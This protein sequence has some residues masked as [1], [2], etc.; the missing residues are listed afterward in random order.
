M[1]LNNS[2]E[3]NISD[4]IKTLPGFRKCRN[5]DL[6]KIIPFISFKEIESDEYLYKAG[7]KSENL[8]FLIEGKIGLFSGKEIFDEISYGYLGEESIDE[9]SYKVDVKALSKSKII[10][11]PVNSLSMIMDV[12]PEFK[13]EIYSSMINHYIKDKK[14]R[15]ISRTNEIEKPLRN[16]HKIIGWLFTIIVPAVIYW[17]V[18]SSDIFE[19]NCK[20]FLTIFSAAITMWIF[21]LLDE[22]I[23]CVFVIAS[24]LI[25][26]VAPPEK[27]LSGFM[28]DEFFLVLSIFGIASVLISSG[29]TYRFVLFVLKYTPQSQ[30][31][32]SIAL[33]F[34]GG[35]ITPIIPSANARIILV[36]PI[37]KDMNE[38]LGYKEAGKASTGLSSA[39][40]HGFTLFSSV[41]LSSKT[42][43]FVVLGLLPEQIKDQFYWISWF[44][45]ALATGIIL[46][47][48]YVCFALLFFRSSE[49]PRSSRKQ[50]E[51]QLKVLGPVTA[52]EKFALLGVLIFIIGIF[53]SSIHKIQ[54]PWLSIAILYFLLSFNI[55]SKKDFRSG[56]DW[57]FLF[58]LGGLIGIVKV[59][60]FVGFDN[61]I[62]TKLSWLGIYMR[63]NFT[64]F[65]LVFYII[66]IITRFVVPNNVVI[67]IFAV[68]FIPLSEANGINPWIIGNIILLFSDHWFFP[69]QCTYYTLFRNLSKDNNFY[70]Q[71]TMIKFNIII[72]IVRVLAVYG[73]IF[74]WRMLGIL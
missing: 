2:A 13:S 9:G 8:F 68:I 73:S 45:A 46:L 63:E 62:S 39:A 25:L 49:V 40:F 44:I 35:I 36:T 47:F 48:F 15:P 16:L 59:M 20:I 37:L 22:F 30:F 32:Y 7:E 42:A 54:L 64:E 1:T 38:I 28:S 71:K 66:I 50:I 26:N 33:L 57:A 34:L 12:N 74:Y 58:Y 60:S 5:I 43:N 27:I 4:R 65:I 70:N 55:L 29:L 21:D 10:I 11:I 6:A 61:Y 41:F 52:A 19:W 56:I 67:A 51:K 31:W 14:E 23:P 18:S 72:N 3:F 24:F 53:T 69:Y 17:T